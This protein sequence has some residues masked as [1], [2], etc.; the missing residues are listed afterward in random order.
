M[1]I[2]AFRTFRSLR[3]LSAVAVALAF[4]GCG[5]ERGIMTVPPISVSLA[6]PKVVVMRAGKPVIVEIAIQS[7]SETALVALTGLPAGIQESYAASDTNPSGT[8][9]FT[10]VA[11]A[12]L[13]MFMP[14]ITVNSA[15]QM[16]STSFTLVVEK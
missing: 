2:A 15:G 4:A 10:A 8:L 14:T 7:S 16:A 12:Q 3:A 6:Q 9:T 13:G 5:G 11:T 1:R